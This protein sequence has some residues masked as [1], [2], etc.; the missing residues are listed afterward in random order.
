MTDWIDVSIP[1]RPGMITWPGDP[2]VRL[3]RTS[4]I[5]SGAA[6]NISELEFG[7][8]AGTHIDAP[9]HFVDGAVGIE[10]VPLDVFVG[11]AL[12]ADARGV[13][14]NLDAAAIRGLA[15]PA[16]TER[17]L[18]RTSNSELWS[19]PAFEPSFVAV[20]ADGADALVALG[21]RLVANDYLSI[22]P[23][24]DA[25]PTHVT[26][27]GAGVAILEGLDLRAVEP[28]WYDLVCLPL[29]IPGSDGGPTRAVVRKA[30]ADG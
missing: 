23:F 27:L 14:G 17:V 10:A 4:S 15:I 24:T 16:G 30:S 3:A 1:I 5:A 26:L 13:T 9:I 22:A 2:D 25:V 12:V 28:G 11:R 29:R 7:V 21:V 19:R 18:F 20:T 6:C 8:H